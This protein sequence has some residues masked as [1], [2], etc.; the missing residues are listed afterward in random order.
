M[1]THPL[2]IS[3][4]YNGDLQTGS[5]PGSESLLPQTFPKLFAPVALHGVAPRH[6]GG[7]APASHRTSLLS[8]N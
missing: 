2:P 8:L 4:G 5:S 1:H 3:R 7:T 6:S